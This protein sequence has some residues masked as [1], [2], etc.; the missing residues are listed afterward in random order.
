M[1]WFLIEVLVALLLAVFIVWITIGG[2]RKPSPPRR[3]S[4]E[5]D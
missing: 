4:E 5:K 2:K 1:V 3:G